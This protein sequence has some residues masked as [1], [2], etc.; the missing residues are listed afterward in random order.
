LISFALAA[1]WPPDA[2]HAAE[3]VIS[4][5]RKT[6]AISR[7]LLPDVLVQFAASAGVSLSFDPT[8]LVTLQSEGLQGSYSIEEGFRKLLHGTGF[9]LIDKG[10]GAYSVQKSATPASLPAETVPTLPT[11]MITAAAEREKESGIVD[12]YKANYASTGT[13][14]KMSID[15]TPASINVVTRDLIRDTFARSQVDALEGVSGISRGTAFGRGESFFIRGFQINN[16]SG[17]FNGMR[18]NGLPTDGVWAPDWAIIERYEVVKGPASIVGGASTPG[19]VVNR[20]TKTPQR[21]NFATTEF[22][23]GS[24]GYYR[25]VIDANG[26]LPGNDKVRGRTVF[27]IEEG[28]DFVNNTPIRQYTVAPSVELDL[29]DRAGKLLLTGMYQHFNGAQY[30]GYPLSSDE[31]MLNIPRTRNFGGGAN[32]GAKT[33][34]TGYN[35][36]LHYDHQFI[37]DLKLSVKGKYSNSNLSDKIIY[38]YAPGGIPSSG[39][40]YLNAGLQ[41][42]RFDTYAGEL[43]L[44]KGFSLLGQKQE[45]LGGIDHRD[46]TQDYLTGY[47]YLPSN[48]APVLDNVFNPRNLFRAPPDSVLAALS[49]D[50]YRAKLKQTGFFAQAI[51]RPFERLTIV[52][53]GRFD[54]ADSTRLEKLTLQQSEQA[55]SAWTGRVGATFK[56]SPWMNVYAGVQQSFQPQPFARTRDGNMLDPETGINYETGAKFN[57]LDDRLRITTALFRTYRQNVSTRDPS[58]FRFQM[59]VGEQRHQGAELDINGEPLPGLNLNANAAYLDARITKDD[60]FAGQRPF[61]APKYVGRVFATYQIQSGPLRGFGFGGGVYFQD[62]LMSF[63]DNPTR[64]DAYERVDAVLFYRGSKRYDVSLNIRNLLDKRFIETPGTVNWGNR[65]GAPITAFGSIRLFF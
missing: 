3:A 60:Q 64:A 59:A 27:A 26:I 61:G 24:F 11:M 8:P 44:S 36:E 58:D 65:F 52:A 41:K 43:T 37:N 56:V 10:D 35:G 5:A 6:Y 47:S 23:A 2:A 31:K 4:P 30:P 48:A 29:F 14:S 15:E 7:G 32:N 12:G 55:K 20:I 62:K 1:A 33:Q 39:D 17:S 57:L 49:G 42:N 28:G 51:A 21:H 13:R 40:A 54:L 19:G 50:P 53:A 18:V 9:D 45:I 38:T 16:R 46:M 25:G 63:T 22:Q 34:F